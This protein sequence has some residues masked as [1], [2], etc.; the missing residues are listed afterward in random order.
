MFCKHE[1]C[2]SSFIRNPAHK[3]KPMKRLEIRPYKDSSKVEL[4]QA[5]TFDRLQNFQTLTTIQ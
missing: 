5:N 1:L 4:I 2:M 3:R